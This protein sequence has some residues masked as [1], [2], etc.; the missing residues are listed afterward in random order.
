MRAACGHILTGSE[1][2]L[3]SL[4]A[5]FLACSIHPWSASIPKP[6]ESIPGF[7]MPMHLTPPPSRKTV[8]SQRTLRTTTFSINPLTFAPSGLPSEPLFIFF[9]LGFGL[10]LL[11]GL[12][13][14][15]VVLND[16]NRPGSVSL[17]IVGD[18]E[19]AAPLYILVPGSGSG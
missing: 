13:L 19:P 6:Y 4:A 11:E 18:A 8:S 2:P 7:G 1:V 9:M 12:A 15:L 3:L 17:T 5:R 16:F 10:V 14:P